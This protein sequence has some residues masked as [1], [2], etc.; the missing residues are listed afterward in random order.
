MSPH[1]HVGIGP[2]HPYSHEI[3]IGSVII[4]A[5]TWI[6]DTFVFHLGEEL[7][8]SIWIGFQVVI[9]C[10]L[11]IIAYILINSSHNKIFGDQ[12]ED[13]VVKTGIYSYIRHPMYISIIVLLSAF[14][15]LSLSFLSLIPLIGATIAFDRMMAFEERELVKILGEQYQAYMIEVP[16]WIP[17]PSRLYGKKR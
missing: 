1:D 5:I 2:E 16:R 9:F 3:Q 10:L 14:F 12:S 17:R 4:F 8:E 6:F 15:V 7:K 11:A 13:S